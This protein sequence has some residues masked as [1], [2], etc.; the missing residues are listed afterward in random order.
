ML[1]IN[2]LSV[3]YGNRTIVQNFNTN[4]KKGDI[5]TIIGPNGSG[6]STV[7]K[8][9]GRLLKWQN[10][11]IYLDGKSVMDMNNK[12]IA[13]TMACLSQHNSC[14]SDMTVRQLVT[15]G[16]HPHK[17]WFQ[18]IKEDDEDIINWALE[19]TNILK[20]QEKKLINLS[21][22]ER[23]RA[24]IAMAL[25]QKPKV[26]LL[27]EPTTYLDVSNQI[28]ILELVQQLNKS[29]D[30]TVVM[31]LHDL[32]QAAKYSHRVLVVKNGDIQV[33]GSPKAVLSRELIRH[34]YKV[35]MDIL[36]GVSGEELIFIPKRVYK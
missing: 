6:K 22:G 5:V 31:V 11:C 23:Q 20:L 4:I 14:P 26:L 2:D 30:L 10:G 8:A 15:F 17:G 32:N 28:E 9:I 29:M 13:R 18:S 35:D 1:K 19:S 12:E 3:G 24:W 33:E 7:L 21:G 36:Q 34:V 25:A 16:R 27:D